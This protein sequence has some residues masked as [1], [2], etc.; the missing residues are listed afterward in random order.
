MKQV[1]IEAL[2]IWLLY[3][4]ASGRGSG[5]TGG[6]AEVL[7]VND[8]S[9]KGGIKMYDIGSLTNMVA[10]NYKNLGSSVDIEPD[11]TSMYFENKYL[12]DSNL[13]QENLI[14]K[15]LGTLLVSVHKKK[16]SVA[17]KPSLL[18]K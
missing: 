9:K 11:L 13:S 4:A 16:I 3:V 8:N 14:A 1:A 12:I 7:L 6:F 2:S 17:I 15:R 18:K 5:K 10:Q